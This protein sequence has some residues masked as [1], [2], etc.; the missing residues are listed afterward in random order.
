MALRPVSVTQLNEY[1][2]RVLQTDPL[3]GNISVVGEI[4]NLKYHGS[5]H[6]Y[7]S[8][9][10][11]GSKVNCFLPSSYAVTLPWQL[12]DGMELVVR[13]YINV[14]KKGGTYTLFVRSIE[15]SGD[16]NLAQAF[17]ILKDKLDREGLFD[18]VHKRPLPKFPRKIGVV[19][20]ETGAAVRDILKIIQSRT[21]LVDVMI[22]PVLVQG[23]GAAADIAAMVDYINANYEDIDTLIVGRGGG[24]MEDLWAFNEEIV[25]RAIFRSRIPIISAVGHE[26]DFTISDFVADRRAETPTA[27]AEMAV[28]DDEKLQEKINLNKDSLLLSLANKVRYQ[29]L[30]ME[31]QR[32]ELHVLLEKRVTEERY[33][34]QRC[35]LIL[36]ENRPEAILDKGYAMV[37]TEAGQVI[38]SVS[39][40]EE[41]QR[42]RIRMKDGSVLFTMGEVWKEGEAGE[43]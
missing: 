39:R 22:F 2:G 4:S 29:R 12:G 28:P 9:V 7:F 30:R 17:Q 24:S 26:I 33:K 32:E 21:S 35:R 15:V 6:V 1:I 18:P 11:E 41:G 27:A 19:T 31:Q 13:G 3:L 34:L 42:Y 14:F 5:G 36:E 10:D 43:I 23:D 37:E 40:L 20:S 8:L 25:A 16:G 38:T